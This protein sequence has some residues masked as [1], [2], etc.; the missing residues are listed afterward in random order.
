M[1]EIVAEHDYDL[2]AAFADASSRHTFRAAQR[3]RLAALAR[4]WGAFAAQEA[5]APQL[6]TEVL[7]RVYLLVAGLRGESTGETPPPW[8]KTLLARA[9]SYGTRRDEFLEATALARAAD[10]YDPRADRVTLSTLH[11]SKGL[12]FPVVFIVGCEE[13]LLPYLPPGRPADAEEERRLFYV[14][15]TRAQQ[16]LLLTHAR[17][18]FLF[19]R[20]TEPVPSPFLADIEQVLKQV[21]ESELR[22]RKPKT[23]DAQLRLL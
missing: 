18:R 13:G 9:A 19:G 10:A 1:A 17:H 20:Q 23:E 4:A 8:F 6:V 22:Q 21:H 16:R 5:A 11:A 12:E 3:P 7:S 14:G 2:A 15:M